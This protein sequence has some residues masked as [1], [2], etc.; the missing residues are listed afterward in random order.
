MYP[1]PFGDDERATFP[2]KPGICLGVEVKEHVT[3]FGRVGAHQCL[4][5]YF[6]D[7][8]YRKRIK[9]RVS[10]ARLLPVLLR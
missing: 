1:L 3:L 7:M 4:P 10:R 2:M 8:I 6:L 5:W 9:E